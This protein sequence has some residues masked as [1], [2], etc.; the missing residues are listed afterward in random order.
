MNRIAIPCFVLL[1]VVL[2]CSCAVPLHKINGADPTRDVLIQCEPD[3]AKVF[4]DGVYVGRAKRFADA[5]HPLK[6]TVGV[7]VIEFELDEYQRE[8]REVMTGRDQSTI[9]LQMRLRPKPPEED[10]D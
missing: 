6:V 3:N 7:H 8:L 10:K 9:T 5:K 4:L 2:T 1:I